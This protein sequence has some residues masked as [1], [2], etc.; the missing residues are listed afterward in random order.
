MELGN[1]KIERGLRDYLGQCPHF[2]EEDI[3][4]WKGRGT[5]PEQNQTTV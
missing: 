2:I 1:V 3:E 4:C 5:L